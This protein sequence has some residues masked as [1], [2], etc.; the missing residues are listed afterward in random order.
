MQIALAIVISCLYDL[1]I[2][3]NIAFQNEK[4]SDPATVSH[5]REQTR[6]HTHAHTHIRTYTMPV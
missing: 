5:V 6:T 2:I 1:L 3:T 4:L